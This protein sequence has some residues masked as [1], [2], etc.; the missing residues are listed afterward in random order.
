[1]YQL[2]HRFL[3]I[4][5]STLLQFCH[6][7]SACTCTCKSTI[8]THLCVKSLVPRL[9]FIRAMGEPG[10]KAKCKSHTTSVEACVPFIKSAVQEPICAREKKFCITINKLWY[11]SQPS[12]HCSYMLHGPIDYQA[13][14]PTLSKCIKFQGRVRKSPRDWSQLPP[15][16]CSPAGRWKCSMDPFHSSQTQEWCWTNQ[17]GGSRR[18]ERSSQSPGR[19]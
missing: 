3:V 10:N 15:V 4:P 8:I 18:A 16:W 14:W 17:Y 12:F 5:R 6:V 11:H 19:P 1:M 13:D 2:K 7:W 9:F